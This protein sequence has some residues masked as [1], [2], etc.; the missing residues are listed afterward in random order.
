VILHNILDFVGSERTLIYITRSVED[1]DMFDRIY[2]FENGRVV[3]SG[4]FKELMKKKKKFYKIA[5][6]S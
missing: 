3:E 4:S 5:K 2:F 6:E 1:L